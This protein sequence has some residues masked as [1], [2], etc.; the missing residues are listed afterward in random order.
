MRFPA[1][2]VASCWIFFAA[3]EG[4]EAAARPDARASA[5]AGS[6]EA[7]VG[8]AARTTRGVVWITYDVPVNDPDALLCCFDSFDEA[9]RNGWRGGRCSLE[10]INST[11]SSHSGDDSAAGRIHRTHVSIYLRADAGRIGE[12]RAFS[13]DC[14]VD[15]GG[16]ELVRLGEID[17]QASVRYLSR[18]VDEIPASK[19]S[20]GNADEVIAAIAMHRASNVVPALAEIVESDRDEELRGQAAFWLGMKGGVEARVTLER[21]ID[22][23]PLDELREQAIA[24]IAQDESREATALLIRMARD[25]GIADVRKKSLFWLGQRAGEAVAGELERAAD[26]PD[27]EVREMAVF[28]ISQLP[29]EQSIPRLLELARSHRNP[30]VRE[31]AFLWLGQSGDPRALDLFE[32]ILTR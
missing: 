32:E 12:V 25:H 11:F 31:Q 8:D 5:E 20:R 7:R 28:S 22:S 30:G 6:L 13:P 24:G 18:L 2:L 16:P 14:P 23:V 26:D 4:T 15:A 9:K 19:A 3:C 17:A 10:S 27:Q 21:I 29:R 1:P